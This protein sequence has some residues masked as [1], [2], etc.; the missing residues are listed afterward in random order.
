MEERG[1]RENEG[2]GNKRDREEIQQLVAVRGVASQL[3][4]EEEEAHERRC[5]LIRY[6]KGGETMKDRR[7][8]VSAAKIK[9]K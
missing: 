5:G 4:H 3:V 8:N 9:R 7:Q 1:G 6:S 2:G